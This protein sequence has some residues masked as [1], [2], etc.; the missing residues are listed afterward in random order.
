MNNHLKIAMLY[1]GKK[2]HTLQGKGTKASDVKNFQFHTF[3]VGIEDND[4]KKQKNFKR[5]TIFELKRQSCK[6]KTK[7]KTFNLVRK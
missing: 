1:C 3:N 6:T 4:E 2:W 7:Y 5:F